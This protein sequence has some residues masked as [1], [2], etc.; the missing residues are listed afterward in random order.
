MAGFWPEVY[1]L[2]HGQTAWNAAGRM[3]G[4]LDSALTPAGRAQAL[5]QAG[6]LAACDLSGFEPWCSPQGRAMSTAALALPS[7]LGAPRTDPRLREIG[8]GLWEGR[9]RGEIAE[10]AGAE[11][12]GGRGLAA[13]DLAPGGEGLK[14]LEARCRAFLSERRSPLVIVTHG[15][16]SRVLRLV[17]TGQDL[18]RIDAI[19]GG[20]G[21]VWHL[22]DG[23]Q[24]RLETP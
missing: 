14:A 1:V 7:T 21:I 5:R 2:R 17:L 20:Q 6:I 19:G 3:Q 11:D 8:V 22:R 13:Y 24:R 12:E 10:L 9:L 23:V 16:T 18:G 15:I 4:G